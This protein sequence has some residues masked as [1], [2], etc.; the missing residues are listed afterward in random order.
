MGGL[1][2]KGVGGEPLGV[3]VGAVGEEQGH[4]LYGIIMGRNNT[5]GWTCCFLNMKSEAGGERIFETITVLQPRHYGTPN[6]MQAASPASSAVD[7]FTAVRYSFP[8]E[9]LRL[10]PPHLPPS[11]DDLPTHGST[12]P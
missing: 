7:A 8:H 9:G 4:L 3:E 10:L 11:Q 2:G 1:L 5:I 6:L 12:L